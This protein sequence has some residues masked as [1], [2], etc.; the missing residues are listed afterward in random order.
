MWQA[1]GQVLGTAVAVAITPIAIV[2]VIMF[3]LSDRGRVKG[4]LFLLGWAVPVFIGVSAAYLLADAADEATDVDSADGIG[5]L[6][7]TLGLVFALL[8][9]LVWRSRSRNGQPHQ[10]PKLVR[11]IES[12]SPLGALGLGVI[13]MLIAVKTYP[14]VISAGAVLNQSGIDGADAVTALIVFTVIASITIILPVVMLS[15]GGDRLHRPFEEF[16]QWL[17]DHMNV[18]LLVLFVLLAANNIGRG[19]RVFD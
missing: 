16:R 5:V 14:L 9:Y 11:K 8:A 18:I 7:L 4:L 10:E 1:I 12:M 13:E 15:F 17:L 3:M 2:S 19:L 6:H